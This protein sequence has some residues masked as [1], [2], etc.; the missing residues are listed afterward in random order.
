M[1]KMNVGKDAFLKNERGVF[2][3]AIYKEQDITFIRQLMLQ[4][5]EMQIMKMNDIHEVL[6]IGTEL[7]EFHNKKQ[8]RDFY[9]PRCRQMQFR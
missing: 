3:F 1:K 5:G 9:K 7:M 6:H 8:E 2:S 4:M